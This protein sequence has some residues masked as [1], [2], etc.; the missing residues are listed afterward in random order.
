L[1]QYR[2]DIVAAQEYINNIQIVDGIVKDVEKI[3]KEYYQD[4]RTAF[5]FT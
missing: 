4:D 5:L 3:I 1:A 2:V